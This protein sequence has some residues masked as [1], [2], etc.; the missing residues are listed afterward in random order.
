[1]SQ[2]C[3]AYTP[4][5]FPISLLDNRLL[6]RLSTEAKFSFPFGKAT[7]PAAVP[8]RPFRQDMAISTS[9]IKSR[10]VEA[11]VLFPFPGFAAGGNIPFITGGLDLR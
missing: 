8:D 10:S 9:L 11:V 4:P 3:L 1:M 5:L 7:S 2:P 6:Y